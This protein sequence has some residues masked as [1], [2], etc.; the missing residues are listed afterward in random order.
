MKR[1]LKILQE[2][3]LAVEAKESSVEPGVNIYSFETPKRYIWLYT[4]TTVAPKKP[5]AKKPKPV[6]PTRFEKVQKAG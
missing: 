2:N 1:I 5:R 3:D 6:N 4:K